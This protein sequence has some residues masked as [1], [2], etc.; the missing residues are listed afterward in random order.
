MEIACG[1]GS[2]LCWLRDRGYKE[3][4]GIDSSKEQI[5]L[6]AQTGTSVELD[7]AIAWVAKQPDS[8]LDAI[9]A[10]DFA[11]HIS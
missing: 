9:V 1:H 7:D 2:F 11:E 8:S 4:I 10:I 6:A 5:A 3:T